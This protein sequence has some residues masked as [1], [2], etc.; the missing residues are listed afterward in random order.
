MQND[1]TQKE[2]DKII[3]A[4]FMEKFNDKTGMEIKQI[5]FTKDEVVATAAKLNIIIRN[6]PDIIYTYRCRSELPES[7][8]AKGNWLIQAK[9][10]GKYAFIRTKRPPFIP[11]QEGL[12][13][14]EI[15]NA[16]PELVEKYTAYDEQGLL[17]AVRYNRLVDVFT[18]ITCFH[19]QSHIRT[20]IEGGQ[21]EVD[22][23]YVGLDQN[24]KAYI[25]PLEAKSP[26]E[27]DRLNWIQVSNLVKY[28]KLKFPDLTCRPIAAKPVDRNTIYLIEFEDKTD[29]EEI[30][31]K[32]IK[33]YKLIRKND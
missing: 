8:R 26:E 6:I 19:L 25:L 9:S 7:I 3:E 15:L 1:V 27:K 17:S 20:T 11:I 28:A 23:L 21:I 4:L 16:L 24:G 10:K 18:E 14:V 33:L 30:G 22:D 13:P 5:D 32:N 12:A 29:F 2:Y 31:I